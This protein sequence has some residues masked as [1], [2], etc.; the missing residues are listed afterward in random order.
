MQYTFS[1][2]VNILVIF[3]AFKLLLIVSLLKLKFKGI[4][5][6]E[7]ENQG[8]FASKQSGTLN[9]RPYCCPLHTITSS[10]LLLLNVVCQCVAMI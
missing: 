10:L 3:F 5:S 7:R 4:F 8:L 6:L 2:M 9:C 1:K